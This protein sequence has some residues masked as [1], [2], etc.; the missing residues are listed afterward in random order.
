MGALDHTQATDIL[1]SLWLLERLVNTL[2]LYLLFGGTEEL[3]AL[4][5]KDSNILGPD[6]S[7]FLEKRCP[8]ISMELRFSIEQAFIFKKEEGV[9]IRVSCFEL[10]LEGMKWSE[11]GDLS[12][13]SGLCLCISL[14][15]YIMH[16]H[17]LFIYIYYIFF[18]NCA[19]FSSSI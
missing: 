16:I 10:W 12:F 13:R 17:K 3:C 4:K 7:D 2:I 8:C 5:H 11:E 6:D 15:V 19:I 18:F 9:F 1:D 14:F